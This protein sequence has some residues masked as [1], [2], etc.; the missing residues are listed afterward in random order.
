M[1]KMR[2]YETE[3]GDAMRR[4]SGGIGWRKCMRV[5]RGTARAKARKAS[6]KTK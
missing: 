4:A 5:A 3:S 2:L 1:R 6:G